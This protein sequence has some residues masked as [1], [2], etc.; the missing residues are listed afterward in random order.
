MNINFTIMKH[1]MKYDDVLCVPCFVHGYTPPLPT[2]S[3]LS[4]K[5][6]NWMS[7][8]LKND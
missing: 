2:W 5:Y 7:S 6:T 1:T 4:P 3:C 8:F